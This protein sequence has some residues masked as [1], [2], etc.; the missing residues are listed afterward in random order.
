MHG[1]D[2][3]NETCR[4]LRLHNVHQSITI[5]MVQ[6]NANI[7]ESNQNN[8]PYELE[9]TEHLL[10]GLSPISTGILPHDDGTLRGAHETE[11]GQRHLA[12]VASNVKVRARSLNDA[13]AELLA[14][15]RDASH[16]VHFDGRI[17]RALDD[18]EGLEALTPPIVDSTNSAPQV[19]VV[20]HTDAAA[21]AIVAIGSDG[22]GTLVV[23]EGRGKVVLGRDGLCQ[24]CYEADGE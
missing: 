5:R 17:V 21:F 12:L 23:V 19:I 20:A 14:H 3:G 13:A 9:V 4:C 1:E 10:P 18:H 11:A 15:D 22:L 8:S 24:Q 16:V 7:M 6:I 2:F